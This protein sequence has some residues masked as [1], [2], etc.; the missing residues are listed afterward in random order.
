MAKMVFFVIL[1]MISGMV[2][3]QI[4]ALEALDRVLVS[5]ERLVNAFGE[6]V[7]ELVNINQQVQIAADIANGQDK[8]QPFVYILQIKND[9]GHVVSVSTIAGE[10]QPIQSFN[11]ALS[12]RPTIAGTY[13]AEIFVWESLVNA[14]ALT[15]PI[16]LDII[17]S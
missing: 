15:E 9:E 14:D 11:A 17:V 13:V 3:P 8:D 4:F 6:Q 1:F 5:S 7:N 2:L 12:W 16:T 10:L